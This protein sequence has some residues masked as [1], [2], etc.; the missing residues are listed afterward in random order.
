MNT[1][2]G[3]SGVNIG[4]EVSDQAL[5][6]G[7]AVNRWKEQNGKHPTDV[8][9]LD[10][11]KSLGYRKDAPLTLEQLKLGYVKMIIEQCKG[12]KKEAAIILK[13]SLK[14]IYNILGRES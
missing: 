11:A 6:F 2:K 14:T 8:E 13:I 4:S 1:T 5:E 12:N 3:L 7:L 9:I 10:I